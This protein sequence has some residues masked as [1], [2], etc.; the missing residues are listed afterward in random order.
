MPYDLP[1][2]L[3]EALADPETRRRA[4]GFIGQPA[5]EAPPPPMQDVPAP[6]PEAPTA[7]TED[8]LIRD[9]L[10]AQGADTRQRRLNELSTGFDN[11]AETILGGVG[12]RYA[13][14]QP[15]APRAAEDFLQLQRTR[16]AL[17]PPARTAA[18]KPTLTDEM[19][20]ENLRA[21]YPD[22]PPGVFDTVTA[23]N[24]EAV[25]KSLEGS[26]GRG[27]RAEVFSQTM[28][29][30]EA[31]AEARAKREAARMGLD[32]AKLGQD[33]RLAMARLE[34]MRLKREQAGEQA[35][36]KRQQTLAERNV[37]GFSFDPDNPP[38]AE[39]S[40]K[41]ADAAIARDEILASLDNLER[42]YS[43][44]G[45]EQ[46]GEKAGVMESE[47]MNITNRL[48]T[49]N[50]MGVPNG[51]DYAMLGKQIEDPTE[52]KAILTS[53]KRGLAKMRTLRD[54]VGRRVDAT[55]RALKFRPTGDAQQPAKP[56][57]GPQRVPVSKG[58]PTGPDGKP[59]LDTAHGRR[60]V[61]RVPSKDRKWLKIEYSDGTS[62]VVPNG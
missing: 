45:S 1:M 52:F 16:A 51:A 18:A 31:E 8:A 32:W 24:Y 33:E 27:A 29:A 43:Q 54:Q 41:M 13:R 44:L 55:A 11:A 4:L 53:R 12:V 62:E 28:A 59:T 3:E 15:T 14:S 26:A 21:L 57:G 5:P 35:A 25:R 36:T 47:W 20:R 17:T 48:R 42:M 49:L 38:S 10:A 19:A 30:R 9:Y 34:E 37:G 60:P 61:R 46:V 22:A 50:E 23:T 6:L 40:K 39:A 58:L 56:T 7:P 2:S